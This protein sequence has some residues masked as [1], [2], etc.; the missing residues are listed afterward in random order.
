[1]CIH[2]ISFEATEYKKIYCLVKNRSAKIGVAQ[3]IVVDILNSIYEPEYLK[4]SFEWGKNRGS[5]YK[6]V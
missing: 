5:V 2:V 3:S 1:M 6:S 4:L